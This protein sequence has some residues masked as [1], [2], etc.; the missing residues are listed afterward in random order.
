MQTD[1]CENPRP[2]IDERADS[3]ITNI[4][5]RLVEERWPSDH[6]ASTHRY[7]VREIGLPGPPP[8]GLAA[9]ICRE[10]YCRNVVEVFNLIA[11]ANGIE[12]AGDADAT[13]LPHNAHSIIERRNAVV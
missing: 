8:Q 7:T 9:I 10:I 4:V 11:P 5:E 2:L 13:L 6:P 12:S 1:H 3:M